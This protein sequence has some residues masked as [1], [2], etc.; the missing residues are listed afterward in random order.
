MSE[1]KSLLGRI[2]AQ[3][4]ELLSGRCPELEIDALLLRARRAGEDQ[5]VQKHEIEQLR[6][7][8]SELSGLL[9]AFLAGFVRRRGQLKRD[10]FAKDT[11]SVAPTLNRKF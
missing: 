9:S 2:E 11:S 10:P 8:S 1:L 5:S 7:A 4:A 6:T 3:K